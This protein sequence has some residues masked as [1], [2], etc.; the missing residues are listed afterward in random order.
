MADTAP[1]A[2]PAPAAPPATAPA[3]A[4]PVAAVAGVGMPASGPG[5]STLPKP[6]MFL[7][8][9][10]LLAAVAVT[11]IIAETSLHLAAIRRDRR[12]RLNAAG[13]RTLNLQSLAE[14]A[15]PDVGQVTMFRAGDGA[16]GTGSGG[17]VRTQMPPGMAAA[18]PAHAAP[19]AVSTPTA[20]AA[21]PAAVTPVEGEA[22]KVP[23]GFEPYR[24]IAVI[25][26][27]PGIKTF[28]F[29]HSEGK[30]LAPFLAG[31]YLTVMVKPAGA[32]KP[33]IRNYS[34]S[35]APHQSEYYQISVK[36]V[37][38][39][40]VSNHVHQNFRAGDLVDLKKP[41]GKFF[42]DPA[43][44]LDLALVA[45]GIGITPVWSMTQEFLS[46][47]RRNRIDLFYGCRTEADVA[48]AKELKEVSAKHE[49]FR[50]HIVLSRADGGWTGLTG[51]VDLALIRRVLLY[52]LR[53]RAYYLCGPAQMMT[54]ITEGLENQGVP[55]SDIHYEAFGPAA[56][57]KKK[58]GEAPAAH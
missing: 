13:K 26:E 6:G 40:L 58:E 8:G 38:K 15:A 25:D 52:N 31:Q 24:V 28:R 17:S 47:G 48:F 16:R 14:R 56:P 35:S 11:L 9:L 4:A 45:G 51:H 32:A 57:R 2:A 30:P 20:A 33:A 10:L 42:L 18:A 39:G 43:Q 46:V 19:A 21:A 12:A 44:R 54:D 37:D 53:G 41:A 50:L 23:A 36:A 29:A 34:L 5:S 3:A 55:T 22:P 1:A 49:N 27:A 7:D